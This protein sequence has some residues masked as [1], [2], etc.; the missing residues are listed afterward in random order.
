M[1]NREKCIRFIF[2]KSCLTFPMIVLSII[3]KRRSAMNM[4][5]LRIVLFEDNWIKVICEIYFILF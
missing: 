2:N 3:R 5:Q 1:E 4:K